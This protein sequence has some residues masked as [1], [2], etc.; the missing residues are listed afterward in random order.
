M[1]LAAFGGP[2]PTFAE[3]LARSGERQSRRVVVQ[4]LT[5]PI[6]PEE[7]QQRMIVAIYFVREMWM[8]SI[9]R[10]KKEGKI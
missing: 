1:T 10:Q 9:R 7:G 8:V 5:R 2:C 3:P 6:T 4:L